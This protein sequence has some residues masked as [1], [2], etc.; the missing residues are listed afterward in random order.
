MAA[1]VTIERGGRVFPLPVKNFEQFL[2]DRRDNV[3]HG[4]Y[5][6]DSSIELECLEEVGCPEGRV[7]VVDPW[8]LRVCWICQGRCEATDPSIGMG[9]ITDRVVSCLE[10]LQDSTARLDNQ[11]GPEGSRYMHEANS[12]SSLR[13]LLKDLEN[14]DCLYFLGMKTSHSSETSYYYAVRW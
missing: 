2:E 1:Q 7:L 9:N 10:D 4:R 13:T 12:S 5:V 11:H 3:L 14:R 6:A 8:Y